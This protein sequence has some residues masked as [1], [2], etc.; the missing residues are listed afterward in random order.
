VGAHLVSSSGPIGGKSNHA[1]IDMPMFIRTGRVG[2]VGHNTF[3]PFSPG[4]VDRV[5]VIFLEPLIKVLE[6]YEPH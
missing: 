4:T 3:T 2:A 6:P 1:G 5:P